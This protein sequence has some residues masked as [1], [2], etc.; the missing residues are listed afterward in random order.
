MTVLVT[1]ASG[2]IGAHLVS[3]LLDQGFHVVALASWKHRGRP[4]RLWPYLDSPRCHVVTADLTGPLPPLGRLDA[5]FHLASE[6]HVDRAIADPVGF[7]TNNV[8]VQLT[9]L[10]AARDYQ[11]R[12]FVQFSTDEVFGEHGN[13]LAPSN[14]YAASKAAQEVL[15]MAWRRTYDIPAVITNCNNV[16]GPGQDAEKFVPRII[17]AVEAGEELAVHTY[18]GILGRRF[19][20]PV[21]N[22]TDA[23][24]FL[25]DARLPESGPT[26]RY[27]IGG[28]VELTNLDIAKLVADALGKPLRYRLIDVSDE[29]P[30][31]DTRYPDG[32][33]ALARLGWAPPCDLDSELKAWLAP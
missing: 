13:Q 20:T 3:E 26:P 2:F 27:H 32:D 17:R 16:V 11:P 6:S 7:V 5:I 33:D 28:G 12:L 22:V 30:G 4:E 21:R 8:A 18:I 14:P 29:R 15:T 9:I 31:Y 24:T 25:L 1:G 10:Q 19:Y 23:L